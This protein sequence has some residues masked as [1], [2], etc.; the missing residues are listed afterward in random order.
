MHIVYNGRVGIVER[1][2]I[3]IGTNIYR[4]AQDAAHTYRIPMI[5]SAFRNNAPLVQ[6]FRQRMQRAD[7][8]CIFREHP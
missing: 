7:T 2:D 8:G 1:I 4:I 3:H 6:F 5:R